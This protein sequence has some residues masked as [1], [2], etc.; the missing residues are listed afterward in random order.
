VNDRIVLYDGGCGFCGVMLALLLKWDRANRLRPVAIQSARGQELLAGLASHDRLKSWHLIDADGV[1]YSGGAGVPVIF[2]ALPWGKPIARG[3]S[4]FPTAAARA[5]DCV[6]N[7]RVLLG[8][9][10]K[11]RTRAWAARVLAERSACGI[12]CGPG[13]LLCQRGRGR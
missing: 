10:F 5:Y 12:G 7:R 2:D 11:A 8:R 9:L 1:L 4:R 3:A 6:A 13:Q